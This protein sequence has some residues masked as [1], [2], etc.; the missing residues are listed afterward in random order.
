MTYRVNVH[1]I[2]G[3]SGDLPQGKFPQCYCGISLGSPAFVGDRLAAVLQWLADHAERC[4][5]VIGDDLHRLNLMM[6]FGL[7]EE[8]ASR[9][10]R[11]QGDE[12]RARLY[13]LVNRYPEGRFLL[14]RWSDITADPQ[15]PFWL[16]QVARFVE[17]NP[18]CGRAVAHSANEYV[19]QQ[20]DRGRTFAR[21][22]EEVRALS[23]QYLTEE[24]AGFTLLSSDG[25]N[26]DVYPGPELPILIEVARGK[27]A[28]VPDPL[29]HRTNVE[30]VLEEI[31]GQVGP[32]PNC[33]RN[34]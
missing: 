9:H 15:F 31:D 4:R 18:D 10:A 8:E 3:A 27:Y 11:L 33:S 30:L 2:I 32:S 6:R 5:L 7:E 23:V 16:D 24:I 17:E 12:F 26:V 1:R 21:P 20:L 25:W 19:K 28:G 29:L 13:P 34:P 14:T 22:L